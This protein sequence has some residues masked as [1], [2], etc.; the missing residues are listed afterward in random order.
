MATCI[1]R[2]IH[3]L[4]LRSHGSLPDEPE[5]PMAG[6]RYDKTLVQRKGKTQKAHGVGANMPRSGRGKSRAGK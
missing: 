1:S 2:D 5:I 4:S 6:V 3:S